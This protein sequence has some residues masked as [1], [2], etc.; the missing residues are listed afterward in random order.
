MAD[1]GGYEAEVVW[2]YLDANATELPTVRG[3]VDRIAGHK[4]TD[5]QRETLRRW[6]DTNARIIP[7]GRWDEIL[8]QNDVM[9][10]E[11][12]QWATER[13]GRDGYVNEDASDGEP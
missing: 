12:E 7:L 8:L 10:W 11:F 5:S 6:R 2:A 4:I 1:E 13:F 9:L 3:G